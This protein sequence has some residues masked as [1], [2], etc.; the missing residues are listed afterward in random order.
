MAFILTVP[1]AP[2]IY[3]GDEIG[4][5]GA[6]DPD[7]RRPMKFDEALSSSEKA[8]LKYVQKLAKAREEISALRH[9][10][11]VPLLEEEDL[12]VYS[13]SDNETAAIVMINRGDKANFVHIPAWIMADDN[14]G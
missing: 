6:G 2:L 5:T 8:N 14:N 11:F 13:R 9:G 3:Y 12:L 7:N 1:G 10:S 4:M